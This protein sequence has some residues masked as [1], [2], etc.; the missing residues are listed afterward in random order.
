MRVETLADGITLYNA[1][2]RLVLPTLGKVDAVITDPPYGIAF[3]SNHVARTTTAGWMRQQIA[4]D[5]TL[6]ARDAVLSWHNGDWLCFGSNKRDAPTDTRGTLVWDKGPSSGMGDLSFP[7]KG[8]FELIFVGGKGWQGSRDEGVIKG[9]WIVTRASMGRVHPNEKPE[10][11]M[12]YLLQ[13][14]IAKLILD[15]FMG[16]G[17]TG[18]AAVKL[19]RKFIGIEIE[20]KYFDIACRRISEALKQPDLFIEPPKTPVQD[21]W[22]E[23]WGKPIPDFTRKLKALKRDG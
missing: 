17:T 7:W 15:P 2:C 20:P 9:H 19:G 13:K 8:S 3:E 10:S 11:L 18:V 4:S 5:T 16:S 14:S 21:S 23:M 22:N 6:D 12:R 1:D